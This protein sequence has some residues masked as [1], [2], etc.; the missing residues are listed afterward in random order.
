M[1]RATVLKT[2]PPPEAER[3]P[4]RSVKAG[5]EIEPRV[6]L[7]RNIFS[8]LHDMEKMMEDAF[9]RPFFG[10]STYP[11]RQLFH[12]FGGHGEFFPAVDVFEEKG[13]V[14]IK[15]DLPGLKREDV[16]LKLVGNSIIISGEKRTEEKVERKD[17]LRVER[18]RGAFSRA[19][20]LPEGVDTEHIKASFKDGILEVRV[21]KSGKAGLGR[22]IAIK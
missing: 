3:A 5:E 2:V 4:L 7:E 14:V 20:V 9:H 19:V 22:Q 12:E 13:D 1:R 18:S 6:S 16:S 21:P 10:I 15:T 8:T 17:Y 11:I